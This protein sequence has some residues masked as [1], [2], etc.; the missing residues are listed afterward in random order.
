MSVALVAFARW[1][2]VGGGG[3]GWLL[4]VW[5]AGPQ[6][7]WPL[8]VAV[9][10]LRLQGTMWS[11]WSQLGGASQAGSAHRPRWAAVIASFM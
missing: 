8:R 9:G 11:A 5:L 1:R 3:L 10:P 6:S 2:G 4:L 7:I